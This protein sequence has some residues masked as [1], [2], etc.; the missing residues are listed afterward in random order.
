MS[1]DSSGRYIEWFKQMILN[2]LNVHCFNL[3]K[4]D[5]P[6]E[7]LIMS[8]Q[9]FL[10]KW[11]FISIHNLSLNEDKLISFLRFKNL[12]KQEANCPNCGSNMVLT[13]GF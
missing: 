1:I 12:I 13:N 8:N 3:N 11:N 2:L 9:D 6:R 4:E 10:Q 7:S 5:L